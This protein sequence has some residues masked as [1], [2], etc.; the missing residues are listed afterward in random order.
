MLASLPAGGTATK[1]KRRKEQ[2][3]SE[4]DREEPKEDKHTLAAHRQRISKERRTCDLVVLEPKSEANPEQKG[5]SKDA[6]KKL[7]PQKKPDPETTPEQKLIAT[8]ADLKPDLKPAAR[9]P[10]SFSVSHLVADKICAGKALLAGTCWDWSWC[11]RAPP[12]PSPSTEQKCK[13]GFYQRSKV[14]GNRLNRTQKLFDRVAHLVLLKR[15]LAS[16]LCKQIGFLQ[17]ALDVPF[18]FAL[19][20]RLVVGVA[21]VGL[22]IAMLV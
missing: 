6:E 21:V 16:L 22:V 7:E 4:A 3:E 8:E 5:C 20:E 17:E 11:G 9:T 13:S 10:T 18:P 12:L 2:N 15:C 14:L 1:L 19:M